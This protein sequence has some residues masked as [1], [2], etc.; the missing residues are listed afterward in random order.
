MYHGSRDLETGGF[1][2]CDEKA[3]LRAQFLLFTFI[4]LSEIR[5]FYSGGRVGKRLAF[6]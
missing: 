4:Y 5:S 1:Q 2:I 3:L 6:C